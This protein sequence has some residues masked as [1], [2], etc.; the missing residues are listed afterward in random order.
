MRGDVFRLKAPKDAR[1]HE[2]QGQ[3]YAVIVGSDDLPLSTLLI[4]P[5]STSVRP[6]VFRPEIEIDG[7]STYVLVEQVTAVDPSRLG[8]AV[9]HVMTAELQAIDEA[10]LLVFGLD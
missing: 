5:T 7:K 4:C 10:L 6:T 8:S 3:R 2:Q 9:G 1:G